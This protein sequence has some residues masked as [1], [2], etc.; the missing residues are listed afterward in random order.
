MKRSR[1]RHATRLVSIVLGAL[2]ALACGGPA[3]RP[4]QPV[5]D[6]LS[7]V[8][9]EQ[10]YQHGL[11]LIGQGDYVRAEQYLAAALDRGYPEARVVPS[12]V[13]ACVRGSRLSAALGYAEPYLERNPGDWPLRLLVATIRMG[14][15]DVETAHR[16]LLR[17]TADHPEQPG[18]YYMLAVLERDAL[19]DPAAAREHFHRYLELD[20]DGEHASEARGA[21]EH[22]SDA[23]GT[24]AAAPDAGSLPVR[25]PPH[26][27]DQ[28]P[29]AP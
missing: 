6:P 3:A 2:G 14:L 10:L 7:T 22:P 16:E 15:G 4:E 1:M 19:A 5:R 18:G 8:T 24:G 13:G 29:E 17:V 20:P 25:L 27:G 11:F 23:S 9:P 12:L 28:A 21:L 26:D